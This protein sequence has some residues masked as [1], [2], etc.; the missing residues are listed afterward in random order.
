MLVVLAA[1]FVF[2]QSHG[3]LL[4]I[5]K[6]PKSEASQCFLFEISNF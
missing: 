5:T 1:S 6:V 3:T 4:N 2:P